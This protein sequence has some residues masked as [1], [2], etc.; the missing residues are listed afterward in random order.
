MI[1]NKKWKLSYILVVFFVI[2]LIISIIYDNVVNNRNNFFSYLIATVS[3]GLPFF[4]TYICNKKKIKLPKN[5]QVITLIVIFLAQYF[6]EIMKF[7]INFW[8][9]DLLLHSIFTAMLL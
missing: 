9:W 3:L 8:W 5:F 4:I 6:G 2:I 1:K 7:Y